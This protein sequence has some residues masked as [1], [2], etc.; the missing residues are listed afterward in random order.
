MRKIEL[1][2]NQIEYLYIHRKFPFKKCAEVLNCSQ[3]VIRSRLIEHSIRIRTTGEG[4]KGIPKKNKISINRVKLKQFYSKQEL[5]IIEC[6]KIL[7]YKPATIYRRLKEYGIPIRKNTWQGRDTKITI[8]KD[9]LID[10]YI[11]QKLPT[12]KCGEKMSCSSPTIL[13]KL[14]EAGILVRNNSEAHKNPSPETLKRI[15]HRRIPSSLEEKFQSIIDKHNLPYKFVGNGSFTIGSYNPDFINTNSEKIAVEVYARYYKL[16]NHISIKK[17]K[18][19]R[20]KVFREY[21]WQII[22]FDETQVN[23]NN[24]LNILSKGEISED[25]KTNN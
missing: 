22:Y 9:I 20:N 15:L 18:E 8:D 4:S 5:N 13:K 17:W 21:G 19:E 16:R 25:N 12:R 11:N 1:N 2:K 6:G 14:R 3:D 10:L 23:K 7:G 24:V